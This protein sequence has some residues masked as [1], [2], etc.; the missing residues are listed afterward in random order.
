MLKWAKGILAQTPRC[1]S[2]LEIGVYLI[3]VVTT[4]AGSH[5]EYWRLVLVDA[6]GKHLRREPQRIL[7]IG[8]YLIRV[9]TTY[10]ETTQR[11][12]QISAYLMHAVRTYA[13]SHR[14]YCRLVLI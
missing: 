8:V 11:I 10:A 6:C 3:R 12:L 9:V 14:E 7:E 2:V 4:Y 13:G 1:H 5:R